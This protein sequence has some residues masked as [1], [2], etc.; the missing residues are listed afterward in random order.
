[1]LAALG[2]CGL[3]S[4]PALASPRAPGD[5]DRISIVVTSDRQWNEGMVWHDARNRLRHQSDLPLPSFDP[6]SKLWTGT[7]TFLS[8]VERQR[9]DVTFTTDGRYA[10]CVVRVNDVT[11]HHQ[12]RRGGHAIARCG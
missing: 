4:A 2:S 3:V 7:L 12:E 10:R 5:G 6:R 11:L 1:M 9:F 8:R